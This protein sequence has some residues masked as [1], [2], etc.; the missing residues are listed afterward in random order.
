M[1]LGREDVH[2]KHHDPT[3]ITLVKSPRTSRSGRYQQ[4]RKANTTCKMYPKHI[5]TVAKPPRKSQNPRHDTVGGLTMKPSSERCSEREPL[6]DRRTWSST[7]HHA[8]ATVKRDPPRHPRQI[9]PLPPCSL[10]ALLHSL[11]KQPPTFCETPSRA[12]LCQAKLLHSSSSFGDG[13]QR[14]DRPPRALRSGAVETHRPVHRRRGLPS[15]RWTEKTQ[16]RILG[17]IVNTT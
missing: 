14:G 1:P 17:W 2:L 16:H 13:R 11:H 10:P 8:L 9:F 4:K 3:P 5:T 6:A 12:A 15:Q 7:T